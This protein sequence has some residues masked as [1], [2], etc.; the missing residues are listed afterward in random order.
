DNPNMLHRPFPRLFLLAIS[1]ITMALPLRAEPWYFIGVYLTWTGDPS[2]SITVN[3]VNLYEETPS[4]GIYRRVGEEG[5]IVVSADRFQM[6]RS[7]RWVRRV[8]LEG[9]EEDTDYE[10]FAGAEVPSWREPLRFRTMPSELDRPVRFVT[11][12]DMMHRREWAD[13]MNARAG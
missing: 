3:W 9:L 8:R 5:G 10:F 11:G 12:G 1:A 13:A 6:V 7:V 2:S 4:E